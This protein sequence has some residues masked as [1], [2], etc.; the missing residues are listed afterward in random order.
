MP[1]DEYAKKRDFDITNEPK[2]KIGS[3]KKNIYVIQEHDASHHHYDL[4]LEHNGVLMSFAIPKEPPMDFGVKR[5]AIKVEDHPIDYATFEGTIPEGQ[6]GA[7]TVKIWDS[8]TFL[9]EK[10]DEKEIIVTIYGKKLTGRY[11]L[12]KTNFTGAKNSWL[13]FK[14]K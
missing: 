4:R 8:G 11:V 3:S 7:G 6:Y 13:F 2:S 1:L 5:L 12:L 10:I 9:P 14:K